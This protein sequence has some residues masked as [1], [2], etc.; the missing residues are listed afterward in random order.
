MRLPKNTIRRPVHIDSCLILQAF[1]K[2]VVQSGHALD[3]IQEG[4]IIFDFR[5][6]LNHAVLHLIQ[7]TFGGTVLAL[8]PERKKGE[9]AS[10]RNSKISY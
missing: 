2:R 4:Q 5:K 7:I 6:L 9:E 10:R 8:A 1:G 3:A